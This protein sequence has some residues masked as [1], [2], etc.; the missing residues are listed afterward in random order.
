METLARACGMAVASLYAFTM[1]YTLLVKDKE[2]VD[3]I[4]SLFFG[5]IAFVAL[6][7]LIGVFS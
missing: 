4:V 2:P 6:L 3:R 1:F 7:G 5:A